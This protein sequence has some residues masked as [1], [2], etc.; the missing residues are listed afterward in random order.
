MIKVGTTTLALPS[1]KGIHFWQNFPMNVTY[2]ADT[3]QV[4]KIKY[5]FSTSFLRLLLYMILSQFVILE[6]VQFPCIA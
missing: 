3:I 1:N 6:E 5:Q 4:L 2:M